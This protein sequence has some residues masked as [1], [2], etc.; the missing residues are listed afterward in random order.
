MAATSP[1]SEWMPAQTG[2]PGDGVAP[3]RWKDLSD[4]PFNRYYRAPLA[5][6]LVRGLVKTPITPDQ[7][8]FLQPFLAA[9]AGYFLT[10]A[11]ARHLTLCALL[12]EARSLLRC[13]ASALAAARQ[14]ANPGVHAASRTADGL[15]TFFL[16][17]GLFWHLHLHAP[18]SGAWSQY[19]S[20]NGVLVLVLL[21]GAMRLLSAGYYGRT[22]ASIAQREPSALR[23]RLLALLWGISSGDAFL[24]AVVV[25][26]LLNRLWEGQLFFASVGLL[27]MVGVVLLNG[28]FVRST[29][30]RW[31][32]A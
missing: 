1:H 3:V 22:L 15:S 23:T 24:S 30:R 10:F 11:D 28:W 27:W 26:L 12:F 8:S 21:Q 4:D 7:V 31:A 18:A 20:V 2:L 14:E 19:V 6:L 16:C 17:A 25:T 9:V 13:T 32:V 29:S 5:R